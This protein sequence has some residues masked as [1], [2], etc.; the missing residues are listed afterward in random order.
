MK[1]DHFFYIDRQFYFNF[2][3]YAEKMI[4]SSQIRFWMTW[5]WYSK[6]REPCI[7][8]FEELNKK[9]G[10]PLVYWVWSEY[11]FSKSREES[12][13]FEKK[14][15]DEAVRPL[16][17]LQREFS[18]SR[19]VLGVAFVPLGPAIARCGER[20]HQSLIMAP[21][22]PQVNGVCFQARTAARIRLPSGGPRSNGT[23]ATSS[24]A[25]MIAAL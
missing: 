3:I 2:E 7:I 13:S 16:L 18:D 25:S 19:E 9:G 10:C 14:H 15:Q 17:F 8:H 6:F 12:S 11:K 5:F 22:S 23:N 20:H 24:S 4:C 21:T 1:S